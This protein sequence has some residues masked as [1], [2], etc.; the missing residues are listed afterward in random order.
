MVE[1]HKFQGSQSRD[2]HIQCPRSVNHSRLH[3]NHQN[4][5]YHQ[6]DPYS[7]TE[8]YQ[9]MTWPLKYGILPRTLTQLQSCQP[10][11]HCVNDQ[12]NPSIFHPILNPWSSGAHLSLL[13]RRPAALQSPIRALARKLPKPWDVVARWAQTQQSEPLWASRRQ[14]PP[15]PHCAPGYHRRGMLVAAVDVHRQSSK[16]SAGTIISS[17]RISCRKSLKKAKQSDFVMTWCSFH[18]KCSWT[19]QSGC[20]IPW[21]FL[22][23]QW[24]E[25]W[26]HNSSFPCIK[27][28]LDL[29]EHTNNIRTH[30]HQTHKQFQ[31]SEECNPKSQFEISLY[32]KSAIWNHISW[33]SSI[34]SGPTEITFYLFLPFLLHPSEGC[35]MDGKAFHGACTC[36]SSHALCL[37]V[38]RSVVPLYKSSRED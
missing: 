22:H 24:K 3:T 13:Y 36:V 30:K 37:C 2:A 21:H 14:G 1:S 10:Y 4:C 38:C 17:M 7:S 32:P 25:V 31:I 6:S 11:Q 35:A 19:K 9:L 12:H 5:V 20:G 28:I 26:D 8:D 29:F 23:A 27:Q 33:I 34:R 18:S 15:A 16:S